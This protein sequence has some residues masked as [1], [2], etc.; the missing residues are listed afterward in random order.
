M[1]AEALTNVARYS[2]ATRAAGRIGRH[3]GPPLG[4]TPDA[5]WEIRTIALTRPA[6]VILYTD[7]LIEG[8]AAPR[9][10]NR[11]GVAPV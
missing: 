1:V 10:A 4:V 2:Q 8:R 9:A 3:N 5:A 6:S 7:G 11:P